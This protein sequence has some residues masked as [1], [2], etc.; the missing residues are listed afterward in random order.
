MNKGQKLLSNG[1]L[2]QKIRN[3]AITDWQ[4]LTTYVQSLPYGRNSNRE[5]FSLVLSEGKGTCSS[6]HAFLKSVAS[7]NHLEEVQLFLG[8]YK[9]NP[10]NTPGIGAVLKA[11]ILDFIPEAHCYL[12]VHGI[13]KDLTSPRSNI[14]I[15]ENALMEELEISPGQVVGFKV[16]YHKD[17]IK[18]WIKEEQI[19][20]SFAEVWNLRELCIEHLS[21]PQNL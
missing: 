18:N 11:S 17:Y 9:M 20:L 3:L 6:K 21:N 1:I 4:T 10:Y 8:M 15:I 19:A 7:E 13:R 5:D 2:S 16:D 14:N 12:K